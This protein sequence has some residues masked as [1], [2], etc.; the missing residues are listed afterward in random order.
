MNEIEEKS[1]KQETIRITKEFLAI[2][3]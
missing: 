2:E 3:Q 1:N